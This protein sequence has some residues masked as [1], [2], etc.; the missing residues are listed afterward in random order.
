M[1]TTMCLFRDDS[2]ELPD[3][4]GKWNHVKVHRNICTSNELVNESARFVEAGAVIEK[5]LLFVFANLIFIQSWWM[6]H[7]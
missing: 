1:T 3:D 4:H 2:H 6:V 5:P 7:D